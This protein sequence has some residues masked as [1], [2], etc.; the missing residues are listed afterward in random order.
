MGEW[1]EHDG[2]GMPIDGNTYVQV[3]FRDGHVDENCDPLCDLDKANYWDDSREGAN[4]WL[5]N[6]AGKSSSYEI[7][8]YRVLA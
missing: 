1:I 2:N 8:A 5:H 4:C 3:R 6:E 7:V